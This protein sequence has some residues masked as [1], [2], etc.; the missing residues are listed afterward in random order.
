MFGR[1]LEYSKAAKSG[2]TLV[3]F[4]RVFVDAVIVIRL[5]GAKINVDKTHVERA[6][7]DGERW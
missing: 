3:V 5:T 2:S 7:S 6:A 4:W 1:K